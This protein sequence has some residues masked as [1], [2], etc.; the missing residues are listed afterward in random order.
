M[1]IF[2]A[3]KGWFSMLFK[4]KAKEEFNIEPISSERMGAWINECVNIYQGNPSW[5]DPDDHIDTVN[6]AKTICSETARL[7]T[8]G[9][10]IHLDG[11]ARAEWLQNQINKIYFQLRRWVEYGCA[12]GTIILKPNGDTTDIYTRNQFEI[13]HVTGDRIDGV[14]FHNQE[15]V[16]KKWYTRLEY[17]R[18]ENDLYIISNKCY[19]GDSPNDTKERIDIALTPWSELSEQ[20]GIMNVNEPLFGVLRMPHANNIDLNSPYGLP[21][22][23]EAIQE[24]RDLDIA[25]SRNSKEIKDSKRTVLADDSMLAGSGYKVAQSPMA[26]RAMADIIGLPDMVK[27]VRGSGQETYYQEINPELNTDTR[28]TGINALL[29]QIGFKVGY[30]NGY[31]VFNEKTGMI[32]ATQVESDDRKTIQL[33]K[34]VRDKLESCL[35]GLIYA[36]DVFASLYRLAPSGKYESAYDFGDITYNREEDRARWWN[37]VQA[38]KVPAWKFFVKFE[39]MTEEDARAMVQEAQPKTP[40]LFGG[41]E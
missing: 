4:S 20:A 16:G 15:K 2:T 19:V 18:F 24:L 41:E 5:L 22:F 27:M 31:F 17:H 29:S 36:L 8:L 7:A 1:S 33:I 38:G 3:I 32:T 13:T 26:A 23:S 11:S 40:T 25:Y 21:V 14:V 10:G 6:F 37:Y 35:N 28:L 9:I 30:S 39:G 12:Y 34:D